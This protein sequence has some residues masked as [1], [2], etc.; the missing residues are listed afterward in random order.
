VGGVGGYFGGRLA[1]TGEDVVFIARGAHLQALQTHGLRVESVLG[2]FVVQPVQAT[3]DPTHVGVVDAVLVG[4]KAWQVSEVAEAMR[5][6][7]GPTTCVVPLQNGVEAPG[8]LA[9]VLG[10]FQVVGGLCG[11]AS[12][13]VAPGHIRH[14]AAEPFVKFGELDN[15]PSARLD[16][17]RHTFVRAGVTT[18][19]PSD[20]QR[21][22][23]MKFLF[24]TPCSGLGALTRSP[25]GIWRSVPETRQMSEQAMHEV[26]AVGHARGIAL[27]ADAL[28]TILA[29]V[30]SV[31]PEV[32]VSMQRDVMAGRPSELDAQIGAVVRLGQ[33]VRVAT[34][35]HAFIYG[36]LLPLELRAR[37]QLQFSG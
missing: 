9:A 36:S 5:P 27:P 19:I 2:D 1:Q 22:L 4:V 30:D 8:Q 17:L 28:R 12:F 31:S 35:L 37:G 15:R 26:L 23:W 14:A 10:A 18:E 13:V 6:L 3:D 32:T 24:I 21:E 25:I 11:L 16:H 33:E 34:P 29:Q 7:V 20:I